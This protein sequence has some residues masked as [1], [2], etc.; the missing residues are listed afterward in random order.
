MNLLE[1]CCAVIIILCIVS[2]T[3]LVLYLKYKRRWNLVEGNYAQYGVYVKLSKQE[4]RHLKESLEGRFAMVKDLTQS[5]YLSCD[6]FYRYK[7][8]IVR[9]LNILHKRGN[10]GDICKDI[11]A[12][13]NLCENG[14]FYAMAEKYR[15]TPG[16]LKTCCYIYWGFKWQQTCTLE[17]I[18]ENAYFVKCSRIRRKFNLSK[19]DDILSFISNFTHSFEQ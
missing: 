15:L 17:K 7:E 12:I 1:V 14:A 9:K 5:F 2:V 10:V 4:R 3:L 8:S 16:E 11:V 18:S 19:D 6:N 13:T